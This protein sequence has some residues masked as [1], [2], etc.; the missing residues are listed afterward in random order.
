MKKVLVT[1]GIIV[2]VLTVSMLIVFNPSSYFLS[3]ENT[4]YRPRHCTEKGCIDNKVFSNLP[5][6][7]KDFRIDAVTI[8]NESYYKQPEAY[9]TFKDNLFYYIN[10]PRDYL[11]FFGYGDYPAE[12]IFH[13][14]PNEEINAVTLF[15]TSWYI[16]TYQGLELVPVIDESIKEYFD[17]TIT[18]ENILLEP[19]FPVFEYNWTQLVRI[20]V[21]LKDPPPGEYEIGI[22]VSNPSPEIS[23]KWEKEY[24]KKYIAGSQ[25]TVGK[26]IY[27]MLIRI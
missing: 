22:S 27:R 25:F 5:K 19:T 20:K 6:Y 21:K 2:I 18:P 1:G 11:G 24:G 8:E 13:R 26:S 17:V 3:S 14:R 9:P 4:D 12:A 15:H 23:Q 10:P 16:I 7:P